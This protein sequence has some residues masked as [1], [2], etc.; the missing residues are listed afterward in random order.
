MP[1]ASEAIVVIALAPTFTAR[2][3][4]RMNIRAALRVMEQGVLAGRCLFQFRVQA[5][6]EGDS[7]FDANDYD[8]G[9]GL[10]GVIVVDRVDERGRHLGCGRRLR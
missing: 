10:D 1:E 8:P 5:G 6:D 2:K 9:A 4:R 3:L 7:P